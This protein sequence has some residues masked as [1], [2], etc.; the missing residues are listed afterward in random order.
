MNHVK[1]EK[2]AKHARQVW[3]DIG[4]FLRAKDI[5]EYS[6]INAVQIATQLEMYPHLGQSC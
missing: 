4:S 2:A 6:P 3:P 5:A 1:A